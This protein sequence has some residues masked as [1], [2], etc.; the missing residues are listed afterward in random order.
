M[1]PKQFLQ[2]GGVVLVLVAILGFVGVIGPTAEQSLFGEFWVFDNIENWAHLVLGVVALAALFVV[3]ANLQ[4]SLVVLVGALALFFGLWSLFISEMFL[5]AG[6]Q[7]PPDTILH[8]AIGVW[9]LW[10]GL[11]GGDDSGASEMPA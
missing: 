1:N 5:G 9:G 10:A 6:L 3:P 7:N 11:R 2:I 4:K 8:L